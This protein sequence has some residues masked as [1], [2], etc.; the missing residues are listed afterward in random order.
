MKNSLEMTNSIHAVEVRSITKKFK[1]PPGNSTR[2]LKQLGLPDRTT[3][4]VVALNDVSF[5]VRRG[6]CF[7]LVGRNGSGKSTMLR[8]IAELTKMSSGTVARNGS[9]GGIFSLGAGLD[10][11]LTAAENAESA[12]ILAG[13]PKQQAPKLVGSIAKWAELKDAMGEPVR[14][15]SDGMKLRLAFSAAVHAPT[16]I[17]VVDEALA[18]GDGRFQEKCLQ[19]LE[20]LKAEGKTIIVISHSLSHVQRLC[21]RTAWLDMGRLIAV[22]DTTEVLARYSARDIDDQSRPEVLDEGARVGDNSVIEI[23]NVRM[24]NLNPDEIISGSA[25][26]VRVEFVTK[27]QVKN[28]NAFISVHADGETYRPIDLHTFVASLGADGR[29]ERGIIEVDISHLDLSA[30]KYWIDAGFMD[31]SYVKMYD[32]RWQ[33]MGFTVEG[34]SSPGPYLPEHGWV[35]KR[36]NLSSRKASASNSTIPQAD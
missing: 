15:F 34:P 13:V 27:Q 9:I 6:E 20:Q 7:G 2:T 14:T 33:A 35:L 10:L 30:G 19:R 21:D 3:S 31:E 18:A 36:E 23:V 24:P 16:D 22:G 29:E 12:L 1:R 4:P 28:V 17:F 25:V 11:D 32:T 26:K 5:D 8:I